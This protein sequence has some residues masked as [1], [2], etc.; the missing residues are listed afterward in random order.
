MSLVFLGGF[1]RD[2]PMA[3]G[4]LAPGRSRG[5][6][7]CRLDRETGRLSPL[8]VAADA[9]NPSYLAPAPSG[10]YLYCVNELETVGDA[11]G[12]MVS[13]YALCGEELRLLGRRLAAGPLA[14]HA[15]LSPEGRHLLAA[16]YNGGVCVLPVEE[17]HTLGEASCAWGFQGRG[18]DPDRQERPHPHQVLVRPGGEFVYVADLGTDRLRCF[19]ADWRRGWLTPAE[20]GDL[21]ARPGQGIRHGVFDASGRRLYVLTEL[22]GEVD[23]FDMDRGTLAQVC[24]ALPESFSGPGMGAAVRMHPNGR[25]LYASLR[26]PGLIA[27]F[28]VGAEGWLAQPA[29]YP[30]GGRTPRDISLTPDGRFLLAGGQDDCSV[31]VHAVDPAEGA[32]R[33]VWRME[34]AGS[35]TSIAV[36]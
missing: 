34:E 4:E 2:I 27:V 16:S 28:P 20:S 35:V 25:F 12:S 1:T 32:L 14:C 29:F 13:A 19:R 31:C 5:I 9:P 23:V 10:K 15:V 30:S 8:S 11:P 17:D 24:S 6:A 22:S 18:R 3:S 33:Q 7:C 26:G 36:L 21:T